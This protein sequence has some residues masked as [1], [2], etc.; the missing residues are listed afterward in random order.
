V[1]TGPFHGEISLCG[2]ASDSDIVELDC[3]KSAEEVYL[4]T[5]IALIQRDQTL[6][7]VTAAGLPPKSLQPRLSL[8]SW[9]PDWTRQDAFISLL[10]R[11]MDDSVV[12][13]AN[14]APLRVQQL[15]ISKE[16]RSINGIRHALGRSDSDWQY[17]QD[18]KHTLRR[19]PREDHLVNVEQLY[20]DRRLLD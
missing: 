3:Q 9:V 18:A 16:Q 4:D 17:L 11:R 1:E 12:Y 19:I 10:T 8:P 6:E 13:P 15:N 5:T 20:R 7:V 2:L 14:C